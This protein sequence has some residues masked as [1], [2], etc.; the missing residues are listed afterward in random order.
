MQQFGGKDSKRHFTVIIGGKEHGLYVSS[1][2]SSA[3]RKAVTKLCSSNKSKKVDFHIREITQG[4]K[5]K[6]YGPYV[7]HIE[8][9]KE[10]IEL[11]GRVI[12][13]KPVAKLSR[14]TGVKKGGM[15]RTFG[16]PAIAEVKKCIH[17]RNYEKNIDTTALRTTPSEEEKWLR[18]DRG[19]KVLLEKEEK[20]EKLG[21]EFDLKSG[22]NY[23]LVKKNNGISGW[24]RGRYIKCPPK[25]RVTLPNINNSSPSENNWLSSFQPKYDA[26][27]SGLQRQ[28]ASLSGLRGQPASLSGLRGQSAYNQG[29][30]ASLSGLRGQSAYNQGPSASLSGLRGQSAYNQG[31]PAS[32]SGL[33]GQSAYNQGPFA[34]LSGLRGQSAYNQGQPA[35]LSANISQPIIRGFQKL[36]NCLD[37]SQLLESI[38]GLAIPGISIPKGQV[39]DLLEKQTDSRTGNEFGKIRV[40]TSRG[41]VEGFVPFENLKKT[42]WCCNHDF[43]LKFNGPYDKDQTTNKSIPKSVAIILRNDQGDI[44]VGT[45]TDDKKMS[46]FNKTLRGYHLCAGKIDPGSCPIISSYD[47]TAEESRF[48]R[49]EKDGNR[50]F[51]SWDAIFKPNKTYRMEPWLSSGRAIVFV[52]DIGDLYYDASANLP[53][54][55]QQRFTNRRQLDTVFDQLRRILPRTE[56]N[57]KYKE[58]INFEWVTPLPKGS[59][60]SDWEAW[61]RRFQMFGWGR[62]IIQDY[63]ERSS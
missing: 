14:E 50:D 23:F 49:V 61:S 21:E 59:S 45:E 27:I 3:A 19:T 36:Y 7:G 47:E 33:R 20:V 46:E 42:R 56:E 22:E 48:L 10:S 26:P 52:G 8:K 18:D 11:K 13:Y 60:E 25:V 2:P 29:P 55:K 1:N 15:Y 9:L 12:K 24:V 28:P 34:S 53:Y 62:S 54:G 44:L 38:S 51:K 30:F 58:K 17:D 41:N 16:G 35:S 43:C 6:T 39:I 5:K 37:N 31:Q 40:S 4:S 63:V 57:H 32:L